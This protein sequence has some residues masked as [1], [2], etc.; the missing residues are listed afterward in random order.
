M[1]V[2][3][4]LENWTRGKDQRVQSG[5]PFTFVSAKRPTFLRLQRLFYPINSPRTMPKADQILVWF[6]L[7]SVFLLIYEFVVFLKGW[8]TNPWLIVSSSAVFLIIFGAEFLCRLYLRGSS[9]LKEWWWVDPPVILA[10]AAIVG[11]FAYTYF[12]GAPEGAAAAMAVKVLRLLRL[13]RLL[14]IA[15]LVRFIGQRRNLMRTVRRYSPYPLA[16][17]Y[18]LLWVL[19]FALCLL[20]LTSL[21]FGSD[22]GTI[23]VLLWGEIKSIIGFL[24]SPET[25]NPTLKVAIQLAAL[26]MATMILN[27]AG[28]L[29]VPILDKLQARRAELEN[30]VFLANHVVIC[31]NDYENFEGM[32]EEFLRVF[33]QYASRDVIV[34]LPE[35]TNHPDEE[36]ADARL[37]FVK[38]NLASVGLWSKAFPDR[39]D[40]VIV[41]G[42]GDIPTDDLPVLIRTA[43]Q[44]EL[45]PLKIFAVS[46]NGPG[47][48]RRFASGD[49]LFEI[50][51]VHSDPLQEKVRDMAWDRTSLQYG[52]LNRLI[53]LF[54]DRVGF[55][56]LS[57]RTGSTEPAERMK[58]ILNARSEGKFAVEWNERHSLKLTPNSDDAEVNEV[59]MMQAVG[60]A[61]REAAHAARNTNIFLYV[62]TLD[63]LRW[64]DI[65]AA[66]K[67]NNVSVFAI[68]LAL[69][70]AIYH[71]MEM[72]GALDGWVASKADLHEFELR[73]RRDN[74]WHS[75]TDV[76]LLLPADH[77]SDFQVLAVRKGTGGAA[78]YE[79][80]ANGINN[81]VRISSGDVAICRDIGK[82]PRWAPKRRLTESD[83]TGNS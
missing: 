28:L 1:S 53:M 35:G 73:P 38:G 17:I 67:D 47:V 66:D 36:N 68:E 7:A 46:S 14:R 4:S 50:I 42:E 56:T 76:A 25:D 62:E 58:A 82:A 11:F 12:F 81:K 43:D 48:S 32:L 60:E 57:E 55:P 44:N 63:L 79:I 41:L 77:R 30:E 9:Y 80:F 15:K 33:R 16:V 72:S 71:E 5:A 70:L 13:F 83:Q 49:P 40:A 75:A 2:I 10:D 52:L 39:A 78:R 29:Y 59:H 3:D 64:N 74:R 21:Y 23:I 69:P 61:C 37:R 34:L 27:V 22:P 20:I 19:F 54:D 26:L 18:T 51:E 31:L 24:V 65:F 8:P 6:V 45:R